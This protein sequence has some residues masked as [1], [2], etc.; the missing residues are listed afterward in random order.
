MIHLRTLFVTLLVISLASAEDA[1][2]KVSPPEAA[3]QAGKTT[4]FECTDPEN[5]AAK[6]M[7]LFPNQTSIKDSM[8]SRFEDNNGTLSIS[9]IRKGDEGEYICTT[10]SRDLN[11]TGTLIIYVMPSYFTE[12]MIVMGINI[13]LVLIFIGCGIHQFIQ[14]RKMKTNLKKHDTT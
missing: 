7:W 9:D 14:G 12:A 5:E 6:L 10:S 3:E 4:T 1:E 2:L 8:D 13:V 11:A